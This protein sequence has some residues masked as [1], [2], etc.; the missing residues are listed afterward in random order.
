MTKRKVACDANHEVQRNGHHDVGGNGHQLT[1][2]HARN[3]MILLHK[4]DDGK[5]HNAKPVGNEVRTG[6][7]VLKEVH[8]AHLHLLRYVLTEQ[9]RRLNQQHHNQHS[10]YDGVGQ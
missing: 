10:K 6:L 4:E 9:A 7:L 5:S 3:H 2:E 8:L 1:G